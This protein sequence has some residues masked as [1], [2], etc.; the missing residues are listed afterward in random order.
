MER[1]FVSDKGNMIRNETSSA[2][3]RPTA[4]PKL[5]PTKAPTSRPTVSPTPKLP[6]HGDL[7]RGTGQASSPTGATV[8]P[9]NS[10]GNFQ[11]SFLILI[12][13]LMLWNLRYDILDVGHTELGKHLQ[14][15]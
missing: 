7:S 6:T 14:T 8:K 15:S 12:L 4:R 3:G 2:A 9:H 13:I 5:W 10:S 1:L 11:L